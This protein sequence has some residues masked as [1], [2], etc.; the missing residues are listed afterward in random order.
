VECALPLLTHIIRRFGGCVPAWT[1]SSHSSF[2]IRSNTVCSSLEV[3]GGGAFLSHLFW[4]QSLRSRRDVY[5]EDYT[6]SVHF[7][8]QLHRTNRG[9]RGGGK[10]RGILL[11]SRVTFFCLPHGPPAVLASVFIA[12]RVQPSQPLVYDRVEFLSGTAWK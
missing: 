11:R 4:R 7:S 9:H 12:T 8:V 10:R 2:S 1:L 3:K 6:C 5:L